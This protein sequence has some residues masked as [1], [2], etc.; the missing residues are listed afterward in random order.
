M[1]LNNI[2]KKD[3]NIVIGAVH[4][5]P[6]FGYSDFPGLDVALESALE[7]VKAFEDGGADAIIIENNYDV[8]HLIKVHPKTV[9]MMVY[10]GRKIK[11]KTKLP[12]GVSVLWNDYKAS[13]LIAKKIG[14]KFIRIPVFVDSVKTSYGNVAGESKKVLQYQ[15]KIRAQGIALF[16]DIHV[17]HATLLSKKSI[18]A[19]AREAMRAGSDALII[20][21]EWTGDAPNI[22]ELSGVRK[23]VADFPIL[24]GSGADKNNIKKLFRYAN[25][26][27]VSTSLKEGSAVKDEVNIKK[28]EQR[29]SKDKVKNMTRAIKEN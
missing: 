2:F 16:T 28:W 20:T 17:K 13:L 19:S 5:P 12:I 8:P 6:L 9:E 15:R 22:K 3:N 27:I 18:E 21:G 11:Q 26:A 29:I 23:T 7:D 25:G 14:G 1:K 4:F 24:I 10:L